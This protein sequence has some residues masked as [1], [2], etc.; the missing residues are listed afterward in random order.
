MKI[1][2]AAPYPLRDLAIDIMSELKCMGHS[3]TSRWLK[4]PDEM[5]D[6]FARQDLA[7]VTEADLLLAFNPRGWEER[8]TGG[9]HVEF[10][11]ALALDKQVVVFGV[12]S[13]IF[14]HLSNVRVI[15]D[16]KEL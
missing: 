3:V 2:I 13:N 15:S 6:E 11:Y 1:Y 10:G 14:H 9:R 16:L 12:K 5:N 7:D 8:G 4:V